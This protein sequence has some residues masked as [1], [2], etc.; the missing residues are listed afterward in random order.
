MVNLPTLHR[1]RDELCSAYFA[2]TRSSDYK[3]N[4]LVQNGRRVPYALRLRNKLTIPKAKTNRYT[5]ELI[6]WCLEQF[7]SASNVHVF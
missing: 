7:R 1:R 6:P 2:K 3:L 4:A 5:N